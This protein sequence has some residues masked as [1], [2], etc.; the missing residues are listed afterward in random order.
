MSDISSYGFGFDNGTAVALGT[1]DGVHTGHIQVLSKTAEFN[2]Q[3]NTVALTFSAPPKGSPMLCSAA[4]KEQLI[5]KAGIDQVFT[6]DF[7]F[8]KDLSPKE[9]FNDILIE[10]FNTKKIVCGFNY[11]FG[12][13]ASGDTALLKDFCDK[14][15]IELYVCKEFLKNDIAVSSTR[16]RELIKHG[17]C[18]GAA[19]LLGRFFEIGETVSTGR[20]IGTALG[21][22]T[23]NFSIDSSLVTPKEGVYATYTRIGNELFA[24]VTNLGPQPTFGNDKSVCETHIIGFDEDIYGRLIEVGFLKRLRDITKFDDPKILSQQI[25]E[26]KQK[27]AVIFREKLGKI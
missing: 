11:R 10:S 8:V 6:L 1:F 15:G 18:E 9:F 19:E 17:D 3:F 24:S 21:F 2:R 7:D 14:S 13:N 16:I 26:D 4:K 27:A 12:K 22:A 20:H 5:L 25:L 23:A